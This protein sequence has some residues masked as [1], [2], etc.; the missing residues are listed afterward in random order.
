M[1]LFKR[2]LVVVTLLLATWWLGVEASAQGVSGR[3]KPYAENFEQLHVTGKFLTLPYRIRVY[4]AD[5]N[6]ITTTILYHEPALRLI[7]NGDGKIRRNQLGENTRP[8]I[9]QDECTINRLQVYLQSVDSES[10]QNEIRSQLK[11]KDAKTD[12]LQAKYWFTSSLI[13]NGDHIRSAEMVA[14]TWSDGNAMPVTFG[15]DGWDEAND[16]INNLENRRDN[17]AM[18]YTFDGVSTEHCIAKFT[19]QA[20]SEIRVHENRRTTAQYVTMKRMSEIARKA[21]DATLVE[22]TCEDSDRRDELYKQIETTLSEAKSTSLW[23]KWEE[24]ESMLSPVDHDAYRN[25]IINKEKVTLENEF[26]EN[27]YVDKSKAAGGGLQACYKTACFGINAAG[28]ITDLEQTDVYHSS[29]VAW[30][31]DG[32]QFKPKA[33][34]VYRAD[35]VQGAIDRMVTYNLGSKESKKGKNRVLFGQS[36]LAEEGD[37]PLYSSYELNWAEFADLRGELARLRKKLDVVQDDVSQA[38]EAIAKHYR[39]KERQ[40]DRLTRDRTRIK[41]C[42]YNVSDYDWIDVGHSNWDIAWVQ[43]DVN[44]TRTNIGRRSSSNGNWV[45]HAPDPD[46]D[47]LRVYFARGRGVERATSRG[48]WKRLGRH[49]VKLSCSK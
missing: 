41:S 33:I 49:I 30:E 6:D 5:G 46:G 20:R 22:L 12:V 29:G 39:K 8:C 27:T 15:V 24:A 11:K 31:K 3:P 37:N 48:I 14:G 10:I 7:V 38:S 17:I 9:S 4:E 45:L 23:I 35:D 36:A 40:I 13:Y 1:I 32:L 25:D 16:F 42:Y 2:P 21:T 43:R 26:R 44:D 19:S 34:A 47:Y 18:H 28:A